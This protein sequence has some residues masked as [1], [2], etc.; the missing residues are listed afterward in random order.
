[1]PGHPYTTALF[2]IA[3]GALVIN[4]IYQ[5]PGNSLIGVAILL[6]GVPMYYIWKRTSHA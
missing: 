4:T 1:M 2:C 6:T 3:C 5:F